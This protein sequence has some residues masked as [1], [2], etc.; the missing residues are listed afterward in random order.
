MFSH[1]LIPLSV[2]PVL[3]LDASVSRS[4]SDRGGGIRGAGRLEPLHS[5]EQEGKA[6]QYESPSLSKMNKFRSFNR[7]GVD[8]RIN[9]QVHR[10]THV[11]RG[12]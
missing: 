1:P 9:E 6:P 4:E 10:G 12:F 8:C 7:L 2:F 11:A 5:E 3:V